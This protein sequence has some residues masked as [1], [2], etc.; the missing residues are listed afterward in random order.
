MTDQT[1]ASTP[2]AGGL[3][4]LRSLKR[5]Q[6]VIVAALVFA[7]LMLLNSFLS[8]Y[9]LSYFDISFLASGGATTAIAAAGQTLVIISGGFDLS[10]GAVVSLVNAVLATAMDPANM[11]ASVPLWTA[12]GIAVGMG[13]GAV[14]GFF[15]AFMRLQPIV[16]T[17]AVMFIVQGLTLL[18]MATPGGFVAPSMAAVY[19]GDTLPGL[20]PAPLTLL[21]VLILA[22]LWLKRT[23]FGVALFAVGS[24]PEA[25]R[26]TGLRTRTVTFFTY[27]LAGGLY[28]LAGVFV[29]AQTGSGDPL[30]GN[31]LLLP[32][33]AAVVIGGTRLGGGKGGILGTILGA[34]ILMIV[35]NL[36]LSLNVSAYYATIAESAVLL[37]AVLAGSLSKDSP[38]SHRLGELKDAL[39]ARRKGW[40]VS[41]R[42]TADHRLAFTQPSATAPKL[43]FMQRYGATLRHALPAWLCL[44][45]VL[46]ATQLV[47][48]GV[49]IG[50]RYWCCP[51][52]SP[53]WRWDRAR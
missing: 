30:V 17:L 15:V 9:P 10:A 31:A 2:R 45:L 14:N 43:T 4:A 33:F 24:D 49:F 39:T 40:L 18:I 21:G 11:E 27:M 20:L 44:V 42:A 53:S 28:G 38:L 47:L 34:Y 32:T 48:G 51:V 52:S 5:S 16:V 8:P 7:G 19:L 12:I 22:W 13:V 23:A 35:V 37:V 25:A 50:W 29:S 6:A 36:L 46:I 3:I 26:A 41:Q 1:L